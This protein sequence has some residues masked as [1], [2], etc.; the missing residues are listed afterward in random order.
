MMFF[1]GYYGSPSSRQLPC[2]L[3]K[4]SLLTHVFF[5]L[6]CCALAVRAAEHGA[7]DIPQPLDNP[8]LSNGNQERVIDCTA[9]FC[10]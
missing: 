8:V 6:C 1:N 7:S 4:A 10:R 2:Y 5:M 9:R 3:L